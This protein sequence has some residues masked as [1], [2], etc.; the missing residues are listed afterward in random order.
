MRKIVSSIWL[1][2]ILVL[3]GCT[4]SK[5]SD[6]KP[7]LT[8]SIIPQQFFVN[9]I[10][11]NWLSV[12]VMVPPGGSPATYEPTPQQMMSLSNSQ[13][14]FKIGHLSF[15]DAWMDKLASVNSTMKIIDTS[16][17][18]ELISDEDIKEEEVHHDH[19]G[20]Q[21]RGVNPHIWL[22]PNL[23]KHQ[24]QI[25][26]K[27]LIELYPEHKETMQ[28]NL[29]NFVTKCDSTQ[30][31][32]DSLLENAKG[33][34]FIVYHPVWSYLARDYSLKQIAIEHNGKEATAD[35]LKH[36]IDLAKA[37]NIK[38][39]FVQKEFSD[40]QAQTIAREIDG[41]VVH[42]NPLAYNWFESMREFGE[43]FQAS[44]K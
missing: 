30:R 41:K 26:L 31:T 42:L 24:A 35:K 17:G 18:L 7:T 32:L 3:V 39:I 40:A 23:V 38:V 6:N 16:E 8:V 10:A 4:P 12:N 29:N 2:A 27:N 20:H 19:D 13:A 14:Y 5:K 44:S 22:S 43:A 37:E 28:Q 1:V 36:I 33:S 11:G 15:E 25:I 21:H 34:S 9:Q